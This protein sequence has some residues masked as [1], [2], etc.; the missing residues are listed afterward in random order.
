M[1][2]FTEIPSFRTRR[3]R[4]DLSPSCRPAVD[5]FISQFADRHSWTEERKNRL[6][7]VG[8]EVVLSLLEE[9][10]MG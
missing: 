10:A 3:L 2:L 1:T 9:G 5:D 7:Q 8:E 6:R 4:V